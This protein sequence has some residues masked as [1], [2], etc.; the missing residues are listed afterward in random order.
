MVHK[1]FCLFTFFF[2]LLENILEGNCGNQ[3]WQIFLN[4]VNGS[5]APGHNALLNIILSGAFIFSIPVAQSLEPS[6]LQACKM[7]NPEIQP[8]V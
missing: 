7:N 3:H 1:V 6:S 4:S 5:L 8:I 2:C